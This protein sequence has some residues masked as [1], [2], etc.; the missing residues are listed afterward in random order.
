MLSAILLLDIE[1]VPMVQA[2]SSLDP[3]WQDL[4]RDKISKTVPE[5]FDPDVHWRKRGGILA[6]FGR[7]ICISTGFF[8]PDEQGQWQLRIRTLYGDDEV[9]ILRK[10][11]QLCERM[12]SSYP[13][14]RFAGHNIREF[15]I[16]YICRRHLINGLALSPALQFHNRKP[17]EMPMMDTLSWWKFGDH[18]NYTSL[19]LLTRVLGIPSPKQQMDGSQVQDEYYLHHNLSGIAAYCEADVIAVAN[20]LLRFHQLPLL[21]AAQISYAH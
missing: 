13:H 2:F 6:E 8:Y 20:I 14:F 12:R 19:A 15:D 18:K 16:P 5:P 1:T 11:T 9:E 17:W 10:F 21:Q 4:F 3:V 7:I